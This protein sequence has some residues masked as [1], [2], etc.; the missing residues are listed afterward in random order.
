M[1][2]LTETE[3]QIY[4]SLINGKYQTIKD[5]KSVTGLNS[6]NAVSNHIQSMREKGVWFL[7][8]SKKP[9]KIKIRLWSAKNKLHCCIN[10]GAI[11]VRHKGNGRCLNCHDKHRA[12]K[13]E[14]QA[15]LKAQHDK[16]Y[17]KVKNSKEYIDYTNERARV[18]RTTETY[19]RYLQKVYR[20]GRAVRAALN[21]QNRGIHKETVLYSC[22]CCGKKIK[23]PYTPEYIEHNMQEFKEYK[24]YL[25]LK[26]QGLL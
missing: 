9:L 24:K 21:K 18:W 14:R 3:K 6:D 7:Y 4:S 17:R 16:W 25:E 20:R 12:K 8:K 2:S 10:C 13:P 22:D 23:T 1:E 11:K 15:Q 19:K 26:H 5:I